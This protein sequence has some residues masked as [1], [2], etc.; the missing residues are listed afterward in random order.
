MDPREQHD[1][2]LA[3]Q[4]AANGLS[5]TFGE[6]Q[7]KALPDTAPEPRPGRMDRQPQDRVD[8]ILRTTTTYFGS[9][10]PAIGETITGPSG[11]TLR[12]ARRPER[13]PGSTIALNLFCRAQ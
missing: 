2:A 5:Y 13:T 9:T 10:L 3:A 1:T 7:F 12:L 6:V 11:E 8:L 4:V